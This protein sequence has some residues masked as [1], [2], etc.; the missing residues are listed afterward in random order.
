MK[1]RPPYELLNGSV[2]V[3]PAADLFPERRQA[4]LPADDA[5][6]G[7]A[8]VLSEQQTSPRCEHPAHL[9]Q[10]SRNVWNRAERPGGDHGVD[11]VIWKRNRLRDAFDELDRESAGAS[12]ASRASHG[13]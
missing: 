7:R 10:R 11:R 12:R 6:L 1:A 13:E 9:G 8:A 5:R 4:V 3:T 2:E